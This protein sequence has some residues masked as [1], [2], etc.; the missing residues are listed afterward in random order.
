MFFFLHKVGLREEGS[1]TGRKGSRGTRYT[2]IWSSFR[3]FH[4]GWVLNL[5]KRALGAHV[6]NPCT[7]EAE[8]EAGGS[9]WVPG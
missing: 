8:A 7:W 6:S 4:G 2:V 3:Y 9:L 1:G 5:F